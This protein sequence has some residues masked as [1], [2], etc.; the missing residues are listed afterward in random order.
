MT[1]TKIALENELIML[2][3]MELSDVDEVYKIA[4]EERIWEHIA[5][6]LSTKKE[7]AKYVH[8]QVRLNETN[9]R[10]VFVIIN[11]ITNEIIGSM[12]FMR[13]PKS[14]LAVR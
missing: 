2:R 8:S 7:V 12:R 14:M 5:Y 4:T 11:R 6:T 13:Y 9:E 10:L 3:L 1:I